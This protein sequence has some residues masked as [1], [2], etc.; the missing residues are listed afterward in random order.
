MPLG[1]LREPLA[2]SRPDRGGCR[3]LWAEIMSAPR[4]DHHWWS[5]SP[6]LSEAQ[7]AAS[8]LG[9]HPIAEAILPRPASPP[10]CLNGRREA[11]QAATGGVDARRRSRRRPRSAADACGRPE[12]AGREVEA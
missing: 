8:D 11:V 1:A 9:H 5:V 3:T 4:L 10:A 6:S 12:L 2:D 7:D